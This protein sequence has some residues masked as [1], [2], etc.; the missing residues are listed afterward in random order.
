MNGSLH[1]FTGCDDVMGREAGDG[2]GIGMGWM[3]L[4]GDVCPTY[5]PPSLPH[6][7]TPGLCALPPLPLLHFPANPE[8]SQV[9]IKVRGYSNHP[10][11]SLPPSPPSLSL[12]LNCPQLKPNWRLS[13]LAKDRANATASSRAEWPPF[14]YISGMA[15]H[16]IYCFMP[17]ALLF[18]VPHWS[19]PFAF[20]SYI[21]VPLCIPPLRVA[22]CSR[23][24]KT[25]LRRSTQYR[26]AHTAQPPSNKGGFGSP[27]NQ[28]TRSS[29]HTPTNRCLSSSQSQSQSQRSI[30]SSQPGARHSDLTRIGPP[31]PVR[32]T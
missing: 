29:G 8:S 4:S 26:T 1:S 25:P 5:L 19:I 3:C 31:I 16:R 7:T 30:W 18:S 22:G 28:P 23:P 21:P 27:S 9:S 15:W 2:I 20:F 11:P 24:S 17:N 6:P 12:S 32:L 14:P 10:H 13:V